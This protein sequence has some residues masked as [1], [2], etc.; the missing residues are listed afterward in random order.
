M[1]LKLF[2][3]W[4]KNAKKRHETLQNSVSILFW[5]QKWLKI[6]FWGLKMQK[7]LQNITK[8]RFYSILG[9]KLD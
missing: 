7:T 5:T 3:G 8:K 4:A 1:D 6:A 2:F 9:T